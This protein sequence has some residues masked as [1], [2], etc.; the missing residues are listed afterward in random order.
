MTILLYITTALLVLGAGVFC[1]VLQGYSTMGLV[2]LGI[3]GIL[4]FYRLVPHFRKKHPKLTKAVVRMF[5]AV[6]CLGLALFAVTE[7]FII[8]ASIG[9]PGADT[10][11]LLVLGARV[12]PDG[13]SLSLQNRIDEAYAYLTAHPASTAILSG[14]KGDDEHIS[15]AQCMFDSLTA[16]GIPESRLW[17]E[18]QSTSTWENLRFTLTLMEERTGQTPDQLAIVTSEYHL[19][20]AGLFARRLGLETIGIPARTTLPVLK[21][22]YFIREAVAVWYHILT[23]GIIHA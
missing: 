7:F 15:E 11:Y 2:C 18:D 5:T 3:V 21:V 16:M 20:R 19:F 14:G 8:R 10:E 23:G 9:N 6:L 12:R 17:M 22:N 13:P 4:W 1:F